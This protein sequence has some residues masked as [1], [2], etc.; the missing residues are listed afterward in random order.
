MKTLFVVSANNNVGSGHIKRCLLLSNELK[1]ETFFIGFKKQSFFKVKNNLNHEIK[2]FDKKNILILLNYCK[3]LHIKRVIID[4]TNVNFEIQ[5]K[6]FGKYFLVIFDNQKKI[7]F[8]SNVIINANPFAQKKDYN[9]RIRNKNF[10]LF[11]GSDYSL[12]NVPKKTKKKKLNHIFFCFGGGDDKGVILQFL[13][14]IKKNNI[15]NEQKYNLVIGPFNESYQKYS[16]YIKKN[17]LKNINL[18][19]KPK[20]IYEIMQQSFFAII[21]PGTLFYELSFYNVSM[22]LIY[23]NDKQKKLANF[24]QNSILVHGFTTYKKVN[25]E[26]IMKIANHLQKN[27][28]K[29]RS[30]NSNYANNSKKIIHKLENLHMETY[31]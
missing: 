30:K 12:I 3:K 17:N 4:H 19:Y 27:E 23:L 15:D 14:Y 22:Y 26:K 2:K 24:W 31:E 20:N 13:T 29:Y 7:N 11:L 9:K 16:N 21:S 8:N 25:F 28:I 18:T 6:L 5:K 1:Q 10:N